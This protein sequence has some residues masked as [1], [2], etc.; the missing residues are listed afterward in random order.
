MVVFGQEVVVF[1]ESASIRENWLSSG[2]VVVFGKEC[3]Y[4]GK[5][6]VLDKRGCIGPK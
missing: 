4:S 3:L 5:L 2:K 1:G 6:A